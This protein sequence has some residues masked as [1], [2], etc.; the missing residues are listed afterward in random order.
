MP[1]SSSLKIT[2]NLAITVPGNSWA[3][4]ANQGVASLSFT[5]KVLTYPTN[6]QCIFVGAVYSGNINQGGFVGQTQN[7][8]PVNQTAFNWGPGNLST[9]FDWQQGGTY[10]LAMTWDAGSLSSI[11]VNDFNGTPIFSVTAAASN[12]GP[13]TIVIGNAF[14][15]S[16][17]VVTQMQ[18]LAI[19][20]SYAL[21]AANVLALRNQSMRAID[22]DPSFSEWSLGGGTIGATAALS[23]AG[24][25]DAN[26][27]G[28]NFSSVIQGAMSAAVYEAPLVYAP[29]TTVVPYVTKSGKLTMLFGLDSGSNTPQPVTAI[30][31]TPAINVQ[32]GGSGGFNAIDTWGPVTTTADVNALLNMTTI[33]N[34][35][36]Y[37]PFVAYQNICGPVESIAVQKGGQN[38]TSSP[39]ASVSGGGG[40][41]CVLGTPVVTQGV[42]SY[43][44]TAGGS[45]YGSAP[46][47]TLTGGGGF[48]AQAT[49]TVSGGAV[50][51]VNVFWPGYGYTS[52]PTVS[53]SA[54][55]ATATAHV[56]NCIRSIPVTT[57]GSGYTSTPTVAITDGTG[58]GAL[59]VAVMG[60]VQSGD[61]VTYSGVS[62]GWFTT[63]SGIAAGTSGSSVANYSGSLEPGVGGYTNFG[64]GPT[65][66][67][68]FGFNTTF[69]TSGTSENK[70]LGVNWWKRA[71]LQGPV[72]TQA[73][74]QRPLT[75]TATSGSPLVVA[76][77]FAITGSGVWTLV[78]D[79]IA[80][81]TPMSVAIQTQYPSNFTVSSAVVA[82]GTSTT[83]VTSI[84]LT[85]GGSGWTDRPAVALTGGGGSGATAYCKINAAGV[86]IGIYLISVGTGYS[87]PPSV[88]F[89]SSDGNGSGA[90]ATTTTGSVING[91]TWQ[92]T[93]TMASGID[94]FSISTETGLSLAIWA[95][96]GVGTYAYSLY[97]EFLFSPQDTAAAAPSYPSRSNPLRKSG[98]QDLARQ[99]QRER[100][101]AH[102]VHGLVLAGCL[103]EPG[104]AAV[105][106]ERRQ[107]LGLPLADARGRYEFYT[108]SHGRAK[109]QHHDRPHLGDLVVTIGDLAFGLGRELDEP[110]CV[111]AR[112]GRQWRRQLDVRRLRLERRYVRPILPRSRYRRDEPDDH[113]LPKLVDVAGGRVRRRGDHE[114]AHNLQIGQIVGF[115]SGT[116]TF[117]FATNNSGGTAVFA[118]AD[119]NPWFVVPTSATSFAFA[120][121]ATT[122]P[123]Q[124]NVFPGAV[125]NVAGTFSVNFDIN[126]NAPDDGTISPEEAAGIVTSLG[127]GAILVNIP[128]AATE[129]LAA[130]VFRRTRD[131]MPKGSQT[132]VEFSNENWNNGQLYS[133]QFCWTMGNLTAWGTG[134][135]GDGNI[136][137][138]AR[139]A[140]IHA[141]AVATYNATDINGNTNRG[142]EIFRVFGD[143]FGNGVL[144]DQVNYLNANSLPA[145]GFASADYEDVPYNFASGGVNIAT[146]LASVA[147]HWP[148]ST[149]YQWAT[150]WT[151]AAYFDYWRHGL[152]YDLSNHGPGLGQFGSFARDLA[153]IA[154]FTQ[155]GSPAQAI[156][157]EG[158]LQQAATFP[159]RTGTD[160]NGQLLDY[161][162]THDLA[163]DPN[164]Y[165]VFTAWFQSM[166][167]GGITVDTIFTLTHGQIGPNNENLWAAAFWHGE[168]VGL[169]DGTLASNGANITNLFW[170]N[171]QNYQYI[172]NANPRLKAYQVWQDGVNNV[173][174]T[175]ATR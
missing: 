74:N 137:Y 136:P 104:R 113:Q 149:A 125:Y 115:Q 163:Y 17:A 92:F 129:A 23:D 109:H 85:A 1:T 45:G 161:Y 158:G 53:F 43:T 37:Y 9:N 25:L 150:P 57:P 157:Y 34:G 19:S 52:A 79:E 172:T 2:G 170:E 111:P 128:F 139:A 65:G 12:W 10:F 121:P 165:D 166:Q 70:N 87:S 151:R 164:I 153:T 58:T 169:G 116:G 28:L 24:F 97:N 32:F 6:G 108:R 15:G 67:C 117:D 160:P 20:P 159:V 68:K 142:G 168:P 134:I 77:Q 4:C 105:P 95:P 7:V 39:S 27:R 18:D 148:T 31:T 174:A 14:P 103:H 84:T 171:T 59:A 5:L 106:P 146:A 154:S 143:Q 135:A 51:A 30:G 29:P 78:A 48:G 40:S 156:G 46:T 21:T 56:S 63:T 120:M 75:T 64:A 36:H 50:T 127:G 13:E 96:G 8:F 99:S 55:A 69:V 119:F 102:A 80:P 83:G 145:N 93:V 16:N 118:V 62:D 35:G 41:G 81:S 124:S 88:T 94:T 3:F 100:P 91:K 133:G 162:L 131:I 110:E 72:V 33:E 138:T 167:D 22:I 66:T 49:A 140:Q 47:V 173:A 112:A 132:Y 76:F 147:S 130:A 101:V 144:G 123:G 107:R 38:Y 155:S 61:V 152:K 42:T 122:T 98:Y 82:A 90:T 44:V 126:V 71:T 54:G 86:I 73:A 114:H 60:G 175:T 11:W 89:T 26:A 141:V